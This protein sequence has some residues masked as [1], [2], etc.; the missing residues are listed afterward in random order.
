MNIFGKRKEKLEVGQ[1]WE[2]VPNVS[3]DVT[4]VVAIEKIEKGKDK[5]A[6]VRYSTWQK[7]TDMPRVYGSTSEEWFRHSF[8]VRIT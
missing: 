7:A 5:R 3:W 6:Y 2:D 4:W 8:P 1:L